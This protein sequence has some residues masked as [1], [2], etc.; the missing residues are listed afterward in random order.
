M[1]KYPI[2]KPK[3]IQLAK[4]Y[5][6]LCTQ[7]GLSTQIVATCADAFKL[8]TKS[9]KRLSLNDLRL[10]WKPI[11]DILSADL[12]LPRRVFEYT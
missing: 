5:F 12:M 2:P 10:P 9:K 8:L 3:R 7:P 4:I 6:H 1:L 11:Y